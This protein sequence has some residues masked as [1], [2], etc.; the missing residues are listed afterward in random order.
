MGACQV[1][2]LKIDVVKMLKFCTASLFS[3]SLNFVCCL[4][5]DLPRGL[6]DKHGGRLDD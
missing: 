5:V 3:L 2:S 6:R 1:L 4:F